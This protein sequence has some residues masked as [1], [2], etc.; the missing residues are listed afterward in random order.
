[1]T[2]A[3]HW[4]TAI[5]TPVITRRRTQIW[6]SLSSSSCK[7]VSHPDNPPVLPGERLLTQPIP[8]VCHTKSAYLSTQIPSQK[9]DTLE[10]D[11]RIPRIGCLGKNSYQQEKCQEQIDALYTCCNLFYLKNGDNASTP[12][13]P[14]A[15]LLRLKMKQRNQ[16]TW[17]VSVRFS[18]CLPP[19]IYWRSIGCYEM[20]CYSFSKSLQNPSWNISSLIFELL[21]ERFL[22]LSS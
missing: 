4:L 6:S 11:E 1:M 12:S 5:Q 16:A 14:K 19:S 22:P 13:C 2:A 10:T 18:S 21:P 8:T 7:P 17:F 15:N 20:V 3:Q 9:R